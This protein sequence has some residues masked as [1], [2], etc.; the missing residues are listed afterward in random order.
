MTEE[1]TWYQFDYDDKPNTAPPVDVPVWIREDQYMDGVTIGYFDGFTF[2]TW[3]GSD[4]CAV[5]WWMDLTYP[6]DPDPS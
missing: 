4:D 2:R 5:S 3:T 1:Q 6:A